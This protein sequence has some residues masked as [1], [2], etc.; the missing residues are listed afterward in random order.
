MNPTQKPE[1][2]GLPNGTMT[3][4]PV[5]P[6]Q[7]SPK[8]VLLRMLGLKD[9]LR[10]NWPL[11]L[12]LIIMGGII[13][14]VNDLVNKKRPYYTASVLFNLGGGG[15]S[16]SFGGDLG[17]IASAFGLGG[18]APDANI[19]VGDNFLIYAKSRPVVEKTLMKYIKVRGQDTLLV[20]YYIRHSG[21]LLEAWKNDDTL[22]TFGFRTPKIN[23][24]YSKREIT[25]IADIITRID[26]E[27]TLQQPDRKSSF[28]RMSA[29]MEDELLSKAFVEKHL[30]TI[31][32]DFRQKQT[33]KTSEM[34]SLLESR[35]D[36]LFRLMTGTENRLATF[37]DQNKQVVM[38]SGLLQEQK[39]ARN[40]TYLQSLYFEAARNAENMRLSLIRESPLFTLIEPVALPLMKTQK[41]TAGLQGGLAIGLLLAILIVFL[42][43]TYRS[44]MND[45]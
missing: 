39:L 40:S 30:E 44:V 7:I 11:I 21:I 35:R 32:E 17:G 29:G 14:F 27:F 1:T 41:A 16:S 25:S 45:G 18:S 10:R 26:G 8:A 33:K 12:G 6:D 34:Y 4:R 2:T 5:P 24:D 20:D 22:Q 19:F 37:Q 3:V 43:E 9:V 42:R 28:I 23:T 36:S 31:E 38:A 13:G 15:S